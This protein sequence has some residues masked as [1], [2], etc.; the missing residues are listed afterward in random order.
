M[1][2]DPERVNEAAFAAGGISVPTSADIAINS[3]YL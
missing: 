1:S 2:V 3:N